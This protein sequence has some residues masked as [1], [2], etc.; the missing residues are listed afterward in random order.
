MSH[1]AVLD[2]SYVCLL[3]R[4]QLLVVMQ[5]AIFFHFTFVTLDRTW[6]I[7]SIRDRSARFDRTYSKN[8]CTRIYNSW[9]NSEFSA[10]PTGSSTAA[11]ASDSLNSATFLRMRS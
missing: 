10:S 2:F 9:A 1:V 11:L 4:L 6:N 5:P 7:A 3:G 8:G